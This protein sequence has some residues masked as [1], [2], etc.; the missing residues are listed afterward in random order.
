MEIKF[1]EVRVFLNENGDI[2]MLQPWMCEDDSLVVFPVH[3]AKAICDAIMQI[4]NAAT[5]D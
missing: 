4:A 1:A 3:Q 5:Q 2:A